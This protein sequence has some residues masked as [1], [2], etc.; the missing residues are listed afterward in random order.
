MTMRSFI[1]LGF[2]LG[3]GEVLGPYITMEEAHELSKEFRGMK[4]CRDERGA[5]FSALP[6][7]AY[8]NKISKR[9]DQA[10]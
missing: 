7:T 5:F 6:Q 2:R 9:R 10:S 3:R 1:A 4:V 8:T